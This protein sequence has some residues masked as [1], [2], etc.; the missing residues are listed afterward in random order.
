M[1]FALYMLLLAWLPS[2]FLFKDYKRREFTYTRT[3]DSLSS[4]VAIIVPKGFKRQE[5]IAD[6]LGNQGMVYHYKE[7]A[8][9]YI[10]YA[11]LGDNYQAFDTVGHIP[12][13][14]LQGGIFYKGIDSTQRW[15]R[16]AQPPFFRIGYRN[17]TSDSE[18]DFDSAVNYIKPGVSSHRKRK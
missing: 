8:E 9:F 13:P 6:S 12:Q 18:V 7:G 3:G 17:V 16:E 14:H 1:R 2:C 5:R 11:P 15:W 4:T 10:L